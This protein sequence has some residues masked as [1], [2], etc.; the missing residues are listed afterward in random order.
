MVGERFL[1]VEGAMAPQCEGGRQKKGYSTTGTEPV[2]PNQGDLVKDRGDS[3][4]PEGKG[5][6]ALGLIGGKQP[7]VSTTNMFI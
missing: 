7:G 5:K 4:N 1:L 2:Q 6:Y 3:D